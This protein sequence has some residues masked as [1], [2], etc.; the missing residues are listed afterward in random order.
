MRIAD[1]AKLL[2]KSRRGLESHFPHGTSR[3]GDLDHNPVDVSPRFARRTLCCD[4]GIGDFAHLSGRL[5]SG[6]VRDLPGVE[7]HAVR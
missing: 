6:S 2:A 1:L 5:C 3:I 7:D 4:L